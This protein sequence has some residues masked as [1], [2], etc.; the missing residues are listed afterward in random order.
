[1]LIARLQIKLFNPVTFWSSLIERIWLGLYPANKFLH[2]WMFFEWLC[3]I[4]FP[5]KLCLVKQSMN[6]PMTDPMQILRCLTSFGFRDEVMSIFL[7]LRDCSIANGADDGAC[8]HRLRGLRLN[9]FFPNLTEHIFLMK[10]TVLEKSLHSASAYCFKVSRGTVL[11]ALICVLSSLICGAQSAASA[12]AQRLIHKHHWS[13]E[14]SPGN[15]NSGRGV[16]R[17]FPLSRLNCRNG[18]ET[19]AQTRCLPRSLSSVLQ[20]PSRK[21]PVKGSKEQGTRGSP[22]TFRATSLVMATFGSVECVSYLIRLLS[23]RKNA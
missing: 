18:L 1:M 7:W 6:L 17:S 22:S 20:Q 10:S 4:E 3:R 16:M 5:G 8:L 14:T 15:W 19:I 23:V 12:S 2:I 21:K 13:P 11:S 9:Q